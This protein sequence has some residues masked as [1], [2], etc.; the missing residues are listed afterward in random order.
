MEIPGQA[1]PVLHCTSYFNVLSFK[2]PAIYILFNV[3]Y[4]S[5]T[6]VK[7]LKVDYSVEDVLRS[8]TCLD[9]IQHSKYF[10]DLKLGACFYLTLCQIYSYKMVLNLTSSGKP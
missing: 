2:H 10:K 8:N 9:V 7:R 5:N 6:Q 4:I 1:I 3:E